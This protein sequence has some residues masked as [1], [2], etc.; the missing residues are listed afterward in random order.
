MTKEAEEWIRK[1]IADSEERR[2]PGIGTSLRASFR[3]IKELEGNWAAVAAMD[4]EDFFLWPSLGGFQ[5]LEKSA[6][7]A[8]VWPDVR[9]N[10]L[11]YLETG[12]LPQQRKRK[13][14][15]DALPEWPL[16]DCPLK[17]GEPG[18]K[19]DFPAFAVLIE[20][21]IREQKPEEVL[22]WYDLR[23]EKDS[24]EKWRPHHDDED[25][26]ASAVQDRFPGRA[27]AIWRK[28]AESQ[29]ART[30]AH[31]YETAAGHLRKMRAVMLKNGKTKEW[32]SYLAS[33]RRDQKRKPR[34]METLDRLDQR[35]ILDA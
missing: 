33:I 7:K 22:R 11:C 34:L 3:A 2:L 31:A 24:A 14:K 6:E 26:V 29:M 25:S 35:P 20:I 13:P 15:D 1:G 30:G 23:E 4:A 16:P 28:L 12:K 8:G 10:A 9:A 18:R 32:E 21:A 27:M 19:Q 5:Q 17:L